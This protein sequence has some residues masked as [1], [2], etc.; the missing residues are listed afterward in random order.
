M[1]PAERRKLLTALFE[2]V[3]QDEGQIVTVKPHAAFARYFTAASEVRATNPK[4][5]TSSGVT[6]KGSTPVAPAF[7]TPQ[8]GIRL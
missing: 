8:I 1:D 6:N 7:V 3:W 5:N 4:A 2:Q